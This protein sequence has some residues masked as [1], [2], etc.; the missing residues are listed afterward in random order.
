[1]KRRLVLSLNCFLLFALILTSCAGGPGLAAFQSPTPTVVTAAPTTVPQAFPLALVETDPPPNSLIGHL[2]PITFYFNQAMNRTSTESALSG[3]P[4]GTFAWNDDSTLLFTPNQPYAPDTTLNLSISNTVQSAS[5]FGIAEPIELAF[6]VSDYLRTTNI[7]PKADAEDVVVDAAIAVSFNQP[8]VALGGDPAS[9]PAAFNIQPAVVGRGEWIN[10]STFVF[11]PEPAMA[12]GTEYTVSLNQDLKTVTGVGLPETGGE[13]N[14]W[15]F[16]TSRPRVVALE[17][18]SDQ[19]LDIEPEIKLT[20]NQPMDKASV[21]SNFVFSG[22]EGTVNGSFTWND[23]ATELIFAPE[24]PL[25][26]DTGYILNV[27]AAARSQNGEI[28]L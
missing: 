15:S 18:V 19:L 10:T 13:G 26:R 14:S 7:L 21:E 4:A 6:P 20:F 28:T 25:A 23:D 2:S 9:Q 27:G 22:T 11:Y 3:L 8:V 1:M 16:T 12:G 24:N 5:G 17:P